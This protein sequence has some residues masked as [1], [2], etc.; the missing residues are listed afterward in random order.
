MRL[1][2]LKILRVQF[3]SIG[4]SSTALACEDVQL[5]AV[6]EQEDGTTVERSRIVL[7]YPRIMSDPE[8]FPFLMAGELRALMQLDAGPEDSGGHLP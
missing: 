7:V 8:Q 4:P 1:P 6:L 2:R 5:T 3:E